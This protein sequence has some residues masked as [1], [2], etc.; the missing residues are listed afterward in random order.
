LHKLQSAVGQA[1]GRAKKDASVPG[2][3]LDTRREL[4]ELKALYA[5]LLGDVDRWGGSIKNKEAK[6]L[7]DDA[8][9]FW[10]E[11]VVPGTLNNKVYQKASKGEFGTD[12]RGF[13]ESHDFYRN[14]VNNQES[15]DRLSP[16]MSQQT[17]D[18]V[19]TLN[20]LPD[21]AKSLSNPLGLPPT[22]RLSPLTQAAGVLAGSPFQIARASLSHVPGIGALMR[23]QLPKKAYF[24][25]DLLSRS[26]LNPAGRASWG[27]LQGPQEKME[28]TAQRLL[29]RK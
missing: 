6:A 29:G 8:R 7:F 17:G 14:L 24:G 19:S 22:E 13:Q 23:S 10:R 27:A 16:Y 4:T 12:P 28:E 26:G 15:I 3:S 18:L 5:N 9:T 21:M 1:V 20:T 25:E 2:S 11:K